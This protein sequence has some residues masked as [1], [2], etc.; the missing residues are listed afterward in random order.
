M[1]TTWSLKNIIMEW[2]L[3]I[4][5]V[6]KQHLLT[7]C[8]LCICKP[9]VAR[10][11]KRMILRLSRRLE[12]FRR[13]L[14]KKHIILCGLDV[15][16]TSGVEWRKIQRQ[17]ERYTRN[18][19]GLSRIRESGMSDMS[20]VF[21]QHQKSYCSERVKCTPLTLCIFTPMGQ[22]HD[23]LLWVIFL[24]AVVQKVVFSWIS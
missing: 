10:I 9:H 6:M 16:Q 18:T 8:K 14:N 2:V 23:Y 12:E 15:W 7:R 20:C 3:M 24:Y 17:K 1:Y 4:V 22:S 21:C 11:C 5:K 19:Q 13:S